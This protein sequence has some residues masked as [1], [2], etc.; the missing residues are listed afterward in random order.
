MLFLAWNVLFAITLKKTVCFALEKGPYVLGSWYWISASPAFCQA[1]RSLIQNNIE[2]FIPVATEI[3][4][5][6]ASLAP[7][8]KR[9]SDTHELDT[10]ISERIVAATSTAVAP[11][12]QLSP[13]NTT[14][15]FH[16][17]LS[18]NS[19]FHIW[20]RIM[21]HQWRSRPYRPLVKQ[22]LGRWKWLNV[23]FKIFVAFWRLAIFGYGSSTMGSLNLMPI[24]ND[25]VLFVL[26]IFMTATPRL[27]W[28]TFWAKGKRGA[29]LVVFV[30][31]PDADVLGED[32]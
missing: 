17:P 26:L 8:V 20:L 30:K 11:A 29:D 10:F 1:V 12:L 5:G 25:L 19:S 22:P 27:F 31:S 24:P 28:P 18:S 3:S 6:T 32:R 14:E 15:I 13:D 2:L 16:R 9:T 4:G 7:E 23:M 21:S